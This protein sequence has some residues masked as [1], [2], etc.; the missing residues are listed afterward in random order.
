MLL[1]DSRDIIF[2]FIFKH[3]NNKTRTLV[4]TINKRLPTCSLAR[5]DEIGKKIYAV[6]AS[7]RRETREVFPAGTYTFANA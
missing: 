7:I 3:Y 4:I 1:D 6:T 5:V 2:I